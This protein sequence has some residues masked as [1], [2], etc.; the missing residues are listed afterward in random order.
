MDGI[1]NYAAAQELVAGMTLEVYGTPIPTPSVPCLV[2]GYPTKLDFDLTF[3]A[4]GTT[5]KVEATF[6]LWF[7]AGEVSSTSARNTLSAIITGATGIKEALDGTMGGTFLDSARVEN[8]RIET[9]MIG[10]VEY[11]AA[12]FE[13]DVIA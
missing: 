6:P 1:A 8:V 10:T 9:M 4:T 2:V 7:I 11:I 5:G 12:L 3:H 13:M